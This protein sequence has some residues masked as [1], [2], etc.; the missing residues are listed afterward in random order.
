MKLAIYGSSSVQPVAT[1]EVQ[2]GLGVQPPGAAE[3]HL[4]FTVLKMP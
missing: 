4:Q 3:F 1:I 2:W